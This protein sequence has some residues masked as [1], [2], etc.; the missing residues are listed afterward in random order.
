[1]RS[2]R[3]TAAVMT[4]AVWRPST[5]APARRGVDAQGA[6]ACPA[7]RPADPLGVGPLVEGDRSQQPA[8]LLGDE[9][10]AGPDPGFQVEDVSDVGLID[11]PRDRRGELAIRH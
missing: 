6:D 1:M 9:Q 3:V 11:G 7:R 5:A 10:A 2:Y 8:R 4:S